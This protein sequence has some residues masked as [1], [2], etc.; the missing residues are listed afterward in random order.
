MPVKSLSE[1]DPKGSYTYADY[2]TWRFEQMVEL[3]KGKLFI[4]SPA[5]ANRHQLI[6]SHL[7]TI[8]LPHFAKHS[9]NVYHAPFDVRL[10]KGKKGDKD[11]TTVVQPDICV[12][13][14]KNKIDERGCLGSPDWII[15]IISPST[16]KKDYNEKYNLYQENGVKE[17][18][19]VNPDA[20]SVNQYV[21]NS[22]GVYM[23]KMLAFKKDKLSPAIFP[24]LSIELEFVFK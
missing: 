18:W 21:L 15:E 11:I 16:A 22:K 17:Y 23:E 5:P 13:C 9:C 24:E 14:D 1:L 12:V 2:L 8:I 10:V 6:S 3:I 20:N 4:L 19:I 7:L